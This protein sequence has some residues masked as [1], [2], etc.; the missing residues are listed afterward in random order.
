MFPSPSYLLPGHHPTVIPYDTNTTIVP[1]IK[2]LVQASKENIAL[3][4]VPEFAFDVVEITRQLLANRFIDV[5]ARLVN[6][7]N[8][9]TASQVCAAGKPLLDILDDVETLLATNENYLLSTWIADARQW[10]HGDASYAA[11]LEYNARNQIT[12][13]GPDGE[14]NDYAS[15]QWSGLV[16][17]YYKARWEAFVSYLCE[18]K[19]N[20]TAYNATLVA[21]NMLAIGKAWDQQILGQRFG[22]VS[23]TKGNTF[24]VVEIILRRWG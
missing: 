11:Y 22:E 8:S 10:A 14:I 6:I 15:K 16:G 5:Y 3:R 9:S 24:A 7:F 4:N 17:G 12:L 19:E 18:L 13:W 21:Q 1:A 20:A 2:L 23:G